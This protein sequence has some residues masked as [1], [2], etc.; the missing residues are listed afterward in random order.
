MVQA[1]RLGGNREL[2]TPNIG[3]S[4]PENGATSVSDAAGAKLR[5]ICRRL[6]AVRLALRMRSAGFFSSS[7][8]ITPASSCGSVGTKLR[9]L[10]AGLV[11][12]AKNTS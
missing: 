5:T 8:A 7:L 11:T 12:C 2:S 1:S 9:M 6:S 10:G 3:V 4:A